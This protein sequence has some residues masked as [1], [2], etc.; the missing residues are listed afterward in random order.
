MC[1]TRYFSNAA[2]SNCVDST[3]VSQR[4]RK[5]KRRER[6]ETHDLVVG[7]ARVVDVELVGLGLGDALLLELRFVVA[8]E[9][10]RDQFARVE[11]GEAG[12]RGSAYG[13]EGK[14]LLRRPGGISGC[15]HASTH[16]QRIPARPLPRPTLQ[17]CERASD[18]GVPAHTPAHTA[19][20]RVCR[21]GVL[22]RTIQQSDCVLTPTT[23]GAIAVPREV[24]GQR[25]VCEACTRRRQHAAGCELDRAGVRVLT[26]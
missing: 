25:R 17:P 13:V 6:D 18:G 20:A 21:C 1:S 14:R 3:F 26:C 24:R 16:N 4:A 12:A 10:K 15:A 19:S 8:H 23:E 9:R 2:A 5:Q 7:G 11:E 22:T